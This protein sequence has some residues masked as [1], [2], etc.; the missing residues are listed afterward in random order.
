[1]IT[2]SRTKAVTSSARP[3]PPPASSSSSSTS[4]SGDEFA[5]APDTDASSDE[6][7]PPPPPP[8]RPPA[9][10]GRPPLPARLGPAGH[11]APPTAPAAGGIVRRMR[12]SQSINENVMRA[13][14]GATEGGT[15]LSAYRSRI[16]PLFQVLEPTIT[17]EES[18]PTP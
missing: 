1:M 8:P 6:S 11:P 7:G 5:T 4:S 10:R 12:W 3:P 9:R 2:R 16:L 13:Y 15:Q 14:Y 17:V 18:R